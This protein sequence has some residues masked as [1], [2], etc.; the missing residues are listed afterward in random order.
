MKR[1]DWTDNRVFTRSLEILPGLTAWSILI[2]PFALSQFVPAVVAYFI[3]SFNLYWFLK[4]MNIMRH[5]I[6]GFSRMWQSMKI[7]WLDRCKAVSTDPA[8]YKDALWKDYEANKTGY[9][10]RAWQEIENLEGNYEVVKN[11]KQVYH[12]VFITNCFESF[13]ITDST[14]QALKD[15]N[16]PNEKIIIVSCGEGRD[17]EGY[18]EVSRQLKEKYGDSFYDIMFFLHQDMP[19]DVI[20]KGPNLT[21]A[22]HKFYAYMQA[23]HPEI[24]PEDVL[25]TTLDADHIVHRDYLAC[26][27][28]KYIIDANR[29]RKTYQPVALLF[30]NIWDAPAPSR[31]LA[32]ASSFWQIVESVRPYRLRTFAAHTQSL[33]TLIVTDFWSTKT[34]VE[35][36]HQYWRTYFA[37]NGDHEMVPVLIPVYQDCVVGETFWMTLNNQYKQRRRWAWGISDFPFIVKNFIK[38]DEIPLGEKMLQTYRHFAGSVSWST[39][40][41]LIAF[42]WVPL[43]FNQAFQDTVLAHNVSIFSSNMLR[44]A[45]VGIFANIWVYLMLLPPLPSHRRKS[46]YVGMLAQ[47]LI[48]PIVSILFSSLPAFESQTR[49]MLGQT[50]NVFWVTPKVRARR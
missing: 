43:T 36:G 13:E 32:I 27:T 10:H 19:E 45:W 9:N 38:H 50:L 49:L 21:S 46:D 25:V 26:L 47:W 12:A 30:N 3:L 23:E 1:A 44:L 37:Y 20:G 24:R 42:A 16:Y 33:K 4:A 18:A 5:M 7:D 15:C 6:S 14:Y 29:H 48:A 17:H 28:Y 40:S 8:A 22:G 39:S 2:L 11:W 34:I 41:F 31:I 35:D